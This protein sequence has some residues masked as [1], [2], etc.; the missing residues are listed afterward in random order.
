[1]RLHDHIDAIRAGFDVE[2]ADWFCSWHDDWVACGEIELGP[3]AGAGDGLAIAG[4]IGERLA[5][6]RADILDAVIRSSGVEQ[7]RGGFVNDERLAASL[8]DFVESG[9]LERFGHFEVGNE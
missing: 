1:M 6:V 2:D 3:V 5:I 8:G 7:Q 4:A 9:D